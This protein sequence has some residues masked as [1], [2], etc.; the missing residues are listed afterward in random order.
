MKK[1]VSLA[2]CALMLFSLIAAA[3]A[4]SSQE[5]APSAGEIQPVSSQL[6]SGPDIFTFSLIG[7]CTIGDQVQN[8]G[9]RSGYVYK[10]G[11]AG[12]DYPF[13][14]VADM[15]A[16]DDLTVANCEGTFSDRRKTTKALMAMIAPPEYAQV[17]KLGNVDVCNLANNHCGVDFG[18]QGQVDTA[19]NLRA[20]G[21]GAFYDDI[22]YSVTVKGV[23]VGFVGYTYPMNAQKL[24][25][26]V[27]AMESL[28]AE[29]CT[30]VIASAHWGTEP[31][32]GKSNYKE[33][34]LDGNQKYGYQLIDAGFDMVFGH[35]SHTCQMIRWYKG[36]VIFYGLSNF[37]FGANAAPRD[38]D[39]VVAQ[40]SFD[41]H[42]DGTL[43]PRELYA[44]P[45]KMHKDSDFRPYPIQDQAGKE[46]VW[47]KM[48]YN[49]YPKHKAS[50]AP[51]LPESFLT[52]GYVDFR[53][54]PV[55]EE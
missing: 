40:I 28:R 26:Y 49:G 41:I 30:F 21:I 34:S 12:F 24:K 44:M 18:K 51:S 46:Q 22:T 1:W 48:Y 14:L 19:E 31:N 39:T 42:E 2:L 50:P 16:Q 11:E 33:Y 17:L 27:A 13:S 32:R 3:P 9:Y 7:D 29:G 52:T 10:I 38:D 23:K 4:E 6:E 47:E 55:V 54:W 25:K 43:T 36:K 15:F 20:L 5:A 35:G 53:T 45:F 8:L 37:T